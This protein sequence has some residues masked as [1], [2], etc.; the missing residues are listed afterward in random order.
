LS[1]G[2]PSGIFGA[3]L[4]VFFC[5]LN[6]S[7]FDVSFEPLLGT[8]IFNHPKTI[9]LWG[10]RIQ[11]VTQKLLQNPSKI[12]THQNQ[13]MTAIARKKIEYNSR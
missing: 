11:N 12:E 6:L 13:S 10:F 1:A 3:F 9:L 4:V 2:D 5:P 7:H 8:P